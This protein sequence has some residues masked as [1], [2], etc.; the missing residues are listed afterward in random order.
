MW[1][2]LKGLKSVTRHLLHQQALSFEGGSPKHTPMCLFFFIKA[3]E[4]T[5][6]NF[7]LR[8]RRDY[9]EIG[10]SGSTIYFLAQL[11]R[12]Q[13]AV[14]TGSLHEMAT[15]R[16][17]SAAFSDTLLASNG[18]GHVGNSSPDVRSSITQATTAPST[19]HPNRPKSF[20]APGKQTTELQGELWRKQAGGRFIIYWA[21]LTLI[22][23]KL[24]AAIYMYVGPL[25]MKMGK[26]RKFFN[27]S[28]NTTQANVCQSTSFWEPCPD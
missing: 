22:L 19:I 27:S 1:E 24:R 7:M 2:G 21:V 12:W 5:K 16:T 13:R 18:Q 23:W 25:C 15:R 4:P 8:Y 26:K 6:T 14:P 10:C 20:R 28:F 17:L 11:T 3:N 9:R